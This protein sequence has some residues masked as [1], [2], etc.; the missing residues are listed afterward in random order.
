MNFFNSDTVVNIVKSLPIDAP[1]VIAV[2]AIIV[3]VIGI[4]IA[5]IIAIVGI[6]IVIYFHYDTKKTN[7]IFSKRLKVQPSTLVKT[8]TFATRKELKNLLKSGV[9]ATMKIICY[10]NK[11]YG[12]LINKI[13]DFRHPTN[14]EVVV[15]SPDHTYKGNT[16][17]SSAIKKLINQKS[18]TA[19]FYESDEYPEIRACVVYDNSGNAIWACIQVYE[20]PFLSMPIYNKLVTFVVRSQESRSYIKDKNVIVDD[21]LLSEIVLAIEQEFERLSKRIPS[22]EKG[23]RDES[24]K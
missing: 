11:G 14:L 5:A 9:V 4:L 1:T 23:D 19:I 8:N 13:R 15:C 21:T 16:S 10:G 6:L 17:H 7:E 20:Y 18:D 24:T 2:A 12:G 3:N 22:D